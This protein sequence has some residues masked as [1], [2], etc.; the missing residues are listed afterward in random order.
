MPISDAY[1]C[2]LVG[3]KPE[4]NLWI[5]MSYWAIYTRVSA[6]GCLDIGLCSE[7]RL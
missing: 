3:G 1:V 6:E 2:R 4:Q 7:V 5:V